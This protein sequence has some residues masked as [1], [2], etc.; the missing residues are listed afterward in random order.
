MIKTETSSVNKVIRGVADFYDVA[1]KLILG[2]RRHKKLVRAR[3]VVVY[4]LREELRMSYPA[5]GCKI[6]TRDHTTAIYSYQKIKNALGKD[7]ALQREMED[8][9]R[10]IKGDELRLLWRGGEAVKETVRKGTPVKVPAKLRWKEIIKGA[11][12]PISPVASEREKSML[13]EWRAGKTLG[14]IGE[15]WKLTRERIRQIIIKA[16]LREVVGKVDEGLEIDVEEFLKYEREKHDA[17]RNQKTGKLE[18]KN[19]EKIKKPKRWTFYYDCCRKC[20]TTIIPH[21][22][23]GLCRKCAGIIENKDR[24]KMISQVGGKCEM[25]GRDRISSFQEFGRDFYITHL[26]PRGDSSSEYMILCRECFRNL[27][28]KKMFMTK[29]KKKTA[30]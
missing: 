17:M 8:I 26:N 28:G 4:L 10:I 11:K 3:H 30:E 29:Q 27:A 18:A 24:E 16:I 14:Q 1:P 22:K 25:C 9:K 19:K 20:G 2:R 15:E 12:R 21:Y 23:H 7:L 6:G 13:E 5:I